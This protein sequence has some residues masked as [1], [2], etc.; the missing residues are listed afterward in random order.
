M[1]EDKGKSKYTYH[2]AM[3]KEMIEVDEKWYEI[4][5]QADKETL[6]IET[7][8]S[9]KMDADWVLGCLSK[10]NKFFLFMFLFFMPFYK[11]C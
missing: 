1:N 4:L 8:I 2:T 5:C 3:G 6:E 9:E 10:R 11:K 7:D